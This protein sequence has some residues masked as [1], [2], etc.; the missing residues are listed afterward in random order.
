[1]RIIVSRKSF[2]NPLSDLIGVRK[3]E[4][5]IKVKN[6]ATYDVYNADVEREITRSKVLENRQMKNVVV[7][8]VVS[9]EDLIEL[10][11]LMDDFPQ[12]ILLSD[13]VYEYITFEQKHI[14]VNTIEALRSRSIIVSSFGKTF[15]ITG[16]KIGYLIAPAFLLNEIK[17]S[18][19]V[20]F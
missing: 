7:G 13:E 8:D 18:L 1:M 6:G 11:E 4:N 12:L 14:S 9:K 19:I 10:S 2:E 17:K 15:H 3:S 20:C 16:W 5:N